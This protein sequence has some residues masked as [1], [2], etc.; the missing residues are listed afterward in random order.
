M[1]IIDEE[2][3]HLIKDNFCSGNNN[4]FKYYTGNIS[5]CLNK[6]IFSL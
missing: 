4:I 5:Y 1:N 3:K 2:L 6:D